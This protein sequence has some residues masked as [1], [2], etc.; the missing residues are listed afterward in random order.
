MNDYKSVLREYQVLLYKINIQLSNM[1]FLLDKTNS[2]KNGIILIEKNLKSTQGNSEEF[3]FINPIFN[4]Y[5]K[6]LHI[7][8]EIFN[9]QVTLPIQQFIESFTFATD[10]SLNSFNQIKNNLI[11]NKQKVIKARDDYYNYIQDSNKIKNKEHDTNELFKAKKDNYA[12]LY[13]YEVDKM[14]EIID[15]NNQKYIDAY[16]SLNSLNFSYDSFSK[17]LFNKFI[18]NIENFGNLFIKFSEQLNE[19]LNSH[20]KLIENKTRYTP[21]L[22]P[23]TKRRFNYESFEE[24]GKLKKSVTDNINIIYPTLKLEKGSSL[25]YKGFDDFEI[26]D[27]PIEIMD[28]KKVEEKIDELNNLIKKFPLENELIPSEISKLM[29]ILKEEPIEKEQTFSFIFL[30]NLKKFYKNRVISFK[31]RQNFIHLS[32]IMN[33]ICIKENNT[34]TFNAIIEVSQMI[35]YEN[36]F[37]Y[38]MIQKKNHFFSTKTFWLKII[39]DNLKDNIK[40]YTNELIT[41]KVK[42]DKNI[43]KDV[44]KKTGK[45]KEPKEKINF[46]V[47]LGLDKEIINYNKLSEEKKSIL[48][49]YAFENICIILSK[50]I[51]GMCSFLVPEFISIDI[52]DHYAKLF[53]FSKKTISYF[54]NILETKNI[55]NTLSYKKNSD[56]SI[57]K[58]KLYDNLFI[59]SSTLKYLNQKDFINLLHLSKNMTPLIK[60]KIF[61]FLLS[62]QKLTIEKRVELWGIILKIKDAKELI[63]YKNTKNLMKEKIETNQVEQNSQED[64]NLYTI[65]ADLLRTPYVYKEKEHLEKIGWVL[66]CLNFIRP[67]I[68]YIQGMN[69][70]ALFFYVLLDYDE[71]ETFYYLFALETE[72]KYGEILIEDLKLLNVYFN[73]LDKIINLYKPALY[74]KFTDSYIKT[75]FYS[76]SWFITLFTGIN[77]VFDKHKISKYVLMVF[78]NFLIDGF[79]AIFIS[80]FTI[81]RYHIKQIRKLETEDLMSFMIRDLCQNDIFKNENFDKIKSYYEKNSEKINELLINKLTKITFY[82]NENPYLI[83]N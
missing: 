39:Q 44:N 24:F 67:D 1:S 32:N 30:N 21:Q 37:L 81:V 71:E 5:I 61:K 58:K 12:Q 62:N 52:I 33:N 13:K 77:M 19:S 31:N 82:E 36:L 26:I 45:T 41:Q 10:I 20:L 47:K 73:V 40:N 16:K 27:S 11:E 38:S 54:F 70:I 76:A 60:N 74:Y 69:F 28:K 78:E 72:T 23:E 65:N 56:N 8:T 79:S 68:G 9:E 80:G 29:N 6:D 55:K 50:S 64:K 75:N 57:E 7:S 43:K 4:K 83:K 53:N 46:L 15:K 3:N 22:D 2:F 14:N 25:P 18:K 17:N 66:K 63:D 59:L 42:N 51:P 49:Q 48:S 35:K 34:K